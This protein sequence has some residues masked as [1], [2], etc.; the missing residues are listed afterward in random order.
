MTTTKHTPGPW[1]VGL[2]Q[3]HRIVYDPKGWA[4]CD[5]T[6]YHGQDDADEMK[7]N[8][9]LI[10]AAPELLELAEAFK[11]F[12]EDG[13][14]SERRRVACLEACAAVIAKAEGR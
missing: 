9:A 13:S 6:V 4:V 2:K 3:A 10:A 5:C 11:S 12:L 14:K 7:A 1:H 8:A